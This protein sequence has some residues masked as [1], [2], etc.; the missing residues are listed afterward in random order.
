MLPL[1]RWV[2][3]CILLVDWTHPPT[4]ILS[5]AHSNC[6][7]CSKMVIVETLHESCLEKLHESCLI[8]LPGKVAWKLPDKV[9]WKSCM[10]VAW[11]EWEYNGHAWNATF[12]K[13]Y[14]QACIQLHAQLPEEMECL[15]AWKSCMEKLHESC[16]MWSAVAA[17][18]LLK[19]LV[20]N[21]KHNDAKEV[22]GYVLDC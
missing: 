17:Q 9:A 19:S 14:V 20:G 1:W 2:T 7:A 18:D 10:K 3:V 11:Y 5:S 22:N 16:L 15:V 21:A 13:F 6:L 12:E 8:K 4:H